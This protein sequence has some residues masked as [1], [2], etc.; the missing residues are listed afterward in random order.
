MSMFRNILYD[1]HRLEDAKQIVS[2]N[3]NVN[4][5]TRADKFYYVMGDGLWEHSAVKVRAWHPESS[6]ESLV[7]W[8]DSNV[9]VLGPQQPV[10]DENAQAGHVAPGIVYHIGH[11]TEAD[12]MVDAWPVLYAN[13]GSLDQT[14]MFQVANSI[15]FLGQNVLN[16]VY[17]ASSLQLWVSYAQETTSGT[18]EASE[19]SYVRVILASYLP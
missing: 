7:M 18:V 16:V 19:G 13:Y 14:T 11:Q 5:Q 2:E 10:D 8:R 17:D 15:G 1:A 6:T 9:Q 4:A 3:Y 12:E